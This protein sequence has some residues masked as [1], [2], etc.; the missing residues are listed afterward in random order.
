MQCATGI[1]PFKQLPGESIARWS[2]LRRRVLEDMAMRDLREETQRDYVRFVGGFAAFLRR[3][4]DTEDIRRFQ[5]HQTESGVQPQSING[6]VSALS[7]FFTVALDPS[8]R[9][10]ATASRGPGAEETPGHPWRPDRRPIRSSGE[11]AAAA[12]N[13]SSRTT[14]GDRGEPDAATGAGLIDEEG[15]DMG[16]ETRP[17][18]ELEQEARAVNAPPWEPLPGMVK[19]R[20]A[21]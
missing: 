1:G 5:V 4:P 21:E 12:G 2:P 11:A 6:S 8:R 17:A 10:R 15:T 19:R 7:F 14:G 18:W 9:K 16:G 13:A 20:R 3:P